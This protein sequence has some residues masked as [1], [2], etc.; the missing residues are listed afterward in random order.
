MLTH[1][2]RPGELLWSIVSLYGLFP[3]DLAIQKIIDENKLHG[4]ASI[5]PGQRLVIPVHGLKYTV[6]PGDTLWLLSTRFG[7]PLRQLAVYNNISAPYTLRIGMGIRFP[8]VVCIDPGHQLH[9]DF[10]VEPVG[11]GSTV[12]KQKVSAGAQGGSTGKPEY[13]LNLEVSLKVR[14]LLVAKG[15][16]VIMT[17][18]TND[19]RLSNIARAQIANS[20][21]ADL[22]VRI[23][24][25]SSNN[26]QENGISVLY[27][28]LQSPYTSPDKYRRSIR[29]AQLILNALIRS[30]G[31]HSKGIVPRTD[32]T[33][34]NWSNVPV[35]LVEMGFL[36]N[37]NEDVRMSTPE[38]QNKLAQDMVNG[39]DQYFS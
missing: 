6:K 21:N 18:T 16:N 20:A 9:P 3:V 38:Y 19:V 39:I 32:I 24:A 22:C 34:F 5:Y 10:G 27:P 17:R 14:N 29:A 25:D 1:I 36:S 11:P 31:A 4:A 33:G 15:Y 37:P 8:A 28:S 26:P 35:V 12:M 23:H 13:E 30:T 7:V 2:V